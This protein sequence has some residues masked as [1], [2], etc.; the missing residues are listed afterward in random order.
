MKGAKSDT[1]GRKL[2]VAAYE[3]VTGQAIKNLQWLD[4]QALAKGLSQAVRATNYWWK[5]GERV[6]KDSIVGAIENLGDDY[7]RRVVVVQPHVTEAARAKAEAAK[8]GVNR[9]RL[10]QLSTLLAS[11]WR[12]CN[13]L[14]AKF[15]V[16]WAK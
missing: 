11:A 13:G 14:G 15:K 10:D 12:S 16:I 5:D 4:K 1:T 6:A 8:T 2:S 7:V 9:L 3:V